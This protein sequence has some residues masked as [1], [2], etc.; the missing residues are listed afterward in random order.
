MGKSSFKRIVSFILVLFMLII[1]LISC[2]NAEEDTDTDVN[3]VSTISED[4]GYKYL[5]EGTDFGG[6]EIHI[7]NCLREQWDTI[8][9]VTSHEYNGEAINDDVYAR[10][11][12]VEETLNCKLVENNVEMSKV[13]DEFDK[14]VSSG[15]GQYALF[16]LQAGGVYTS[17]STRILAGQV[18]EMTDISTIHLDE[19]YYY[20][21]LTKAM[22]IGGKS[23]TTGS[24][25]QLHCAEGVGVVMFDAKRLQEANVDMPYDYVRNG[26]WTLE[27]MEGMALQA[28]DLKGDTE[29]KWNDNGS[30]VYGISVQDHAI[31]VL[32]I[33]TDA[34]L[35][36]KDNADFLYLDCKN[37][38][39]SDRALKIGSIMNNADGLIDFAEGDDSNKHNRTA[40]IENRRAA[41]VIQGLHMIR[42]ATRA[43]LEYGVV[44][45]PKYNE[46][47]TNYQTSANFNANYPC[48][49]VAY[50]YPEDAGLV[51]DM[52]SFEA[53]RTFEKVYYEDHLELKNN[54]DDLAEDNIEML[55]LV[56]ST[57]TAD[58]LSI[59]GVAK[60]MASAVQNSIKNGGANLSSAITEN[61]KSVT[62]LLTAMQNMMSK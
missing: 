12:W 35:G 25:A 55:R 54:A 36:R 37:V 7:L 14:D 8:S 50:A 31:P 53:H 13:M 27:T 22:S 15:T 20:Q 42:V 2:G 33:A 26:T 56:R 21:Y 32:M 11:L 24:D 57:I 34:L 3:A 5:P 19:E 48:I 44:P 58:P 41:F 47:Q 30:C 62:G 61:E 10:T 23:Y 39:F 6:R 60:K 16:Y 18:A 38:S 40:M 17:M 51:L 52:L 46:D 28:K 4:E 43:G 45:S 9:Y 49:S 59:S 29:W 1:P